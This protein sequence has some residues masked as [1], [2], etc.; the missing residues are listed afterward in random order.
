MLHTS[1]SRNW[2]SFAW[3]RSACSA[4]GLPL[5]VGFRASPQ[6]LGTTHVLNPA[7]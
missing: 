7:N 2:K 5:M 6:Q 4:S 1:P 3:P